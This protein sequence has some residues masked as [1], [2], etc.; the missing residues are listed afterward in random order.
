MFI[1]F[2]KDECQRVSTEGQNMRQDLSTKFNDAIKVCV[3]K[4]LQ[5][6]NCLLP[7]HAVFA[8]I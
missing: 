8:C 7:S 5:I 2:V 4:L 1:S 3:I 6:I